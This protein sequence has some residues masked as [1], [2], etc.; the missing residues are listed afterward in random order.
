MSYKAGKQLQIARLL[1]AG[2]KTL[3]ELS[4]HVDGDASGLLR[5]LRRMEERGQ[6]G[7]QSHGHAKAGR[8]R[9]SGLWFVPEEM[10]EHAE[11]EPRDAESDTGD[12]PT[13]I[14]RRHQSWVL[15][16]VTTERV[17][18]LMLVLSKPA[19][20][21]GAEWIAQLQGDS[22]GYL[23][24][25]PDEV[26]TQPADNLVAA[27]H[28]ANLRCTAGTVARL[29]LPEQLGENARGV[30]AIHRRAVRAKGSTEDAD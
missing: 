18:D 6:L 12:L 24:M 26:G 10:R 1:L 19:V 5:L 23:V 21:S 22:R 13:A 4:E 30:S 29:R 9:T 17:P 15:A 28:A 27:L 16:E 20:L 8:G 11:A 25:F 7:F 14:L 3:T 2:P